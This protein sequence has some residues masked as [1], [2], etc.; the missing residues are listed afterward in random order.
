[1]SWNKHLVKAGSHSPSID[2]EP[3]P[4]Q[5]REH[6]EPWLSALFQ[7]EHLNVLVGSGFTTAIAHAAGSQVVDMSAVP[8][9]STLSDEVVAAAQKSASTLGRGEPNIEDQIRTIIE[10]IA[11]LRIIAGGSSADESSDNNKRIAA[12]HLDFRV[13]KGV[14]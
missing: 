4:A 7:A 2:G 12:R 14:V 8:F 11:G 5:H 1:M 6:I 9:K 13:G 3:D 10:L